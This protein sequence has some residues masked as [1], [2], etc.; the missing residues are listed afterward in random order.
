[1]KLLAPAVRLAA[2][3]GDGAIADAVAGGLERAAHRLLPIPIG[4]ACEQQQGDEQ[5]RLHDAPL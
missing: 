1:M 3:A 5:D 4:A 2:T